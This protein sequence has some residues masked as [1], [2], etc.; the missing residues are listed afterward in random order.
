MPSFF[1]RAGRVARLLFRRSPKKFRS[2][3]ISFPSAVTLASLTVS[4]LAVAISAWQG[5]IS[6]MALAEARKSMLVP[7]VSAACSEE[8]SAGVAYGL[9][10]KLQHRMMLY[11][12]N[13]GREMERADPEYYVAQKTYIDS[14][15][16]SLI[17]REGG[18]IKAS[19]RM[20]S[21]IN[22]LEDRN[23]TLMEEETGIPPIDPVPAGV[24]VDAEFEN[25]MREMLEACR[26]YLGAGRRYEGKFNIRQQARTD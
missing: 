16:K 2:P 25:S 18:L 14:T 7:Q 6:T 1:K 9:K 8:L 15:Y 13:E 17:Y 20:S 24:D 5:A 10:V 26:D 3:T 4:S 19:E 12:R 11:R 22:M 23:A 21:A